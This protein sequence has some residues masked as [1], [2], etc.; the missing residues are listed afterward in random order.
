MRTNQLDETM[1]MSLEDFKNEGFLQEINRLYLHP[2]GLSLE[3]QEDQRTGNKQLVIMDAREHTS[4]GLFFGFEDLEGEDLEKAQ[5]N[6]NNVCMQLA[7]SI[8]NRQKA[9]G[10]GPYYLPVEQ[11]PGVE[12]I[13]EKAQKANSGNG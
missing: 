5:N 8:L 12:D 2:T 1:K 4:I 9:L 7:K 13:N 11:I 6:Y 10:G 3:I